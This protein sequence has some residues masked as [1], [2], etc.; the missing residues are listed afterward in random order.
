MH[1]FGADDCYPLAFGVPSLAMLASL[2]VLICG[3][4]FYIHKPPSDNIFLKFCAC[5]YHGIKE[6]LKNRQNID[7]KD[8]WLDYAIIKYDQQMIEDSKMVLKVLAVFIPMPIY[9]ALH[10][11]QGSTWIFQATRVD[12]DIGWFTITA[13][14]MISLNP[15]F[16]IILMPFCN[17]FFYPFFAKLKID[18]L[19]HRIAIGA[20]LCI[21]AFILA[22]IVEIQ[23]EQGL[24]SI[25]WLFPQYF[26]LALSEIYVLTSMLNFA[27]V[28]G[29]YRM[30]SVMT[31]SVFATMALGN[32][33]VTVVSS[34]KMF[35]RQLHEF[36][37]FL[38]SLCIALLIF[39]ILM[40][41]FEKLKNKSLNL[42][43][44]KIVEK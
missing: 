23:I 13:D 31:S 37:F 29:P 17:Y 19:L 30:K 9:W 22:I 4:P 26:V 21:I 24:V 20:F 41:Q 28:E 1:C 35:E 25:F 15:I 36:M 2:F 44:E 42:N 32:L 10:Q 12:G 3:L 38:F 6:K 5:I 18:T 34:S 16:S 40:R 8:H 33:I 43:L 39:L 7:K 14:Q 11:Q 27:F